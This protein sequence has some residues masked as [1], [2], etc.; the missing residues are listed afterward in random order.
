MDE[1]EIKQLQMRIVELENQLKEMRAARTQARIST[2]E[3]EAYMKVRSALQITWD[4]FCGINDCR[5]SL[6]I[7]G[8][9]IVRCIRFCDFECT[10]GPCNIC[11]GGFSKGG[12]RFGGLG[13]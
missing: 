10:C 5:P 1:E 7:V 12:G 8:A 3:L 6:C 11:S 9:C 2:E 13:G 4:D